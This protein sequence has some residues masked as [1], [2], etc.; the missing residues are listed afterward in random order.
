MFQFR[1]LGRGHSQRVAWVPRGCGE[2]P[3]DMGPDARSRQQSSGADRLASL[4][5]RH[6]GGYAR[7]RDVVWATG[8]RGVGLVIRGEQ[9]KG[10]TT[11]AVIKVKDLAYGRL[12]A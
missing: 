4:A 6:Q 3:N 5:S 7:T 11:M 9:M 2:G 10:G 8:C 12:R 1:Y